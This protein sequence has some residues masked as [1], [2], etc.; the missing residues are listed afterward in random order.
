MK[1]VG[2]ISGGKDSCYNMIECARNGHEIVALANLS[3]PVE[4][5]SH[6]FQTIGVNLIQ[7]YPECVGVPLY[8]RPLKGKSLTTTQDY[9]KTVDDE[10]EDLYELL[11]L[12]KNE[13]GIEGVS[14]GAILSNYQRVRLENVC[15]RLG[16]VSVCY[17]W[18]RD[19][20]LLLRDM[21]EDVDAILV[22]VACHG[23][24]TRHL[25]KS[26]KEIGF[27]LMG[28]NGINVCGEGGEY[29]T[30]TLDCK[31]FKKKIQVV[32][33]QVIKDSEDFYAP[34][35]YID[36][37]SATVVGKELES[38]EEKQ[39]KE[40][41]IEWEDI[42]ENI[43]YFEKVKQEPIPYIT[44]RTVL[45][46][47]PFLAVS[48]ITEL[49]IEENGIESLSLSENI[50]NA[51]DKVMRYLKEKL[52]SYGFNF[53]N[54]VLMNVFVKDMSNFS[55]LNQTYEK[56]FG[57]NPSPRVT[58]ETQLSSQI[59]IDLVAFKSETISKE[60]LH[61][62]GISYWAPANIGP[63]SQ[64]CRIG[65]I[66]F[67]AGMIGLIPC[68]MTLDPSLISQCKTSLTSVA[69]VCKSMKTE[70]SNC[71]SCICYVTNPAY[72]LIAKQLWKQVCDGPILYLVVPR[73]PR[74]AKVEWHLCVSSHSGYNE[75]INNDP[76]TDPSITTHILGTKKSI[77]S[78]TVGECKI[79]LKAMKKGFSSF[80][81][82]TISG[83]PS[84]L[85][86]VF[87]TFYRELQKS[88]DEIEGGDWVFIK[89]F[90]Q[91]DMNI[92]EALL[93]CGEKCAVTFVPVT[94]VDGGFI[95]VCLFATCL[96]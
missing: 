28:M 91:S 57:I 75:I 27:E 30:M 61:V 4:L 86:R 56:Y 29:E 6:M 66:T 53:S 11:L 23:L 33:S 45:H 60:T 32:D 17:L 22:K 93:D 64:A 8:T 54:I 21:M 69:N 80:A 74:D 89:V 70:I 15:K 84:N 36:F 14:C 35:C 85:D 77:S 51:T 68:S 2:L 72:I 43:P 7:Y 95:S 90:H 67:M 44:K 76:D 19:Q 83:T 58:V 78:I 49:N 87:K 48:G 3:S 46:R 16:L 10:V 31:L 37:K 18:Q 73:L 59:Q 82:A 41:H 26:I 24:N 52:E 34:V 94:H 63:Y 71:I 38:I 12:V 42:D 9:E 92:N 81:L 47:A 79:D 5:D 88:I 25:G 40:F 13:T 96:K 39:P 50:S 62:Q 1:L 55:R 65:D 20:T